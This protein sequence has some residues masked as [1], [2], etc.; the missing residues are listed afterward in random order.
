MIRIENIA[1]FRLYLE[2]VKFPVAKNKYSDVVFQVLPQGI[3]LSS[4]NATHGHTLTK[5]LIKKDGFSH[6][7]LNGEKEEFCLPY[8]ELKHLVDSLVGRE[9]NCELELRFPVG[10]QKLQISFPE[11]F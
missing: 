2:S 7:E 1:A 8:L 11:E 9:S 4:S 5:T 3:V 10:D 6:F